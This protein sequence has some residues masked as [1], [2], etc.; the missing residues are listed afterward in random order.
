[1]DIMVGQ[2]CIHIKAA[3]M[4]T[5]LNAD[6]VVDGIVRGLSKGDLRSF[7]MIKNK[8][9]TVVANNAI[10]EVESICSN[11]YDEG[12]FNQESFDKLVGQ[13]MVRAIHALIGK[14][15]MYENVNKVSTI[16]V[17]KAAFV[18][19][20]KKYGMYDPARY[21][22]AWSGVVSL[23][24]GADPSLGARTTCSVMLTSADLEGPL[25]IMSDRGFTIDT[26]VSEKN[27]VDRAVYCITEIGATIHITEYT[28]VYPEPRKVI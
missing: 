18:Q 21:L 22:G 17:C 14:P 4:A 20:F 13:F 26:K 25:K 19:D 23:E 12:I 7:G 27:S 28:G 3:C 8:E 1:M 5:N 16:E 15:L 10:K 2:P 11:A 24:H 6:K 9:R